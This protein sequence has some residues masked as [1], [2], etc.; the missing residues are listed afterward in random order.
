MVILITLRKG[1]HPVEA[2]VKRGR[3]KPLYKR[4]RDSLDAPYKEAEIER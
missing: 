2:Y 1:N 4:E 3:K